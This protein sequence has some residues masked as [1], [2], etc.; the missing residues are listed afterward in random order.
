MDA[1]LTAERPTASREAM[2][3]VAR[4]LEQ[5]L[6]ER[7]SRKEREGCAIKSLESVCLEQEDCPD[8]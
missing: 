5:I 2:V 1:A 3:V 4:I 6:K 7:I 8:V